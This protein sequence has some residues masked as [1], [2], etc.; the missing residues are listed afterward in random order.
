MQHNQL[1]L[2]ESAK[3]AVPAPSELEAS[4][5]ASPADRACE[6]SVDFEVDRGTPGAEPLRLRARLTEKHLDEGTFIT[7][8]LEALDKGYAARAG[9]PLLKY[10]LK[11]ITLDGRHVPGASIAP[12]RAVL[13]RPGL[14]VELALWPVGSVERAFF[15]KT[16]SYLVRMREHEVVHFGAPRH[17]C[18]MGAGLTPSALTPSAPAHC[19]AGVLCAASTAEQGLGLPDL[20]VFAALCAEHAPF[21]ARELYLEDNGFGDAGLGILAPLLAPAFP[22]LQRLSL[23]G[24]GLTNGGLQALCAA[25]TATPLLELDLSRNGIGDA[26]LAALGAAIARG[27]LLQV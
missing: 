16:R 24:N 6:L 21:E 25:P 15:E 19:D 17:P 11:A 18:L 26:G 2:L 12:A 14:S 5:L 4:A 27:Q 3:T 20:R 1:V 13:T 22:R 23:R 10:H 9:E 7:A 8:C